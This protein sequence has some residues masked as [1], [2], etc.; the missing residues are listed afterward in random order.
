M[1]PIP[2]VIKETAGID[3][4]A[5]P[6]IGGIPIERG[7]L[8]G[9]PGRFLLESETGEFFNI[10][11]RPAAF[12]PD[13]TAKWLHIT[14]EVD[15]KGGAVNRFKLSPAADEPRA[16][17]G[18]LHVE[19]CG[20]GVSISGGVLDVNVLP[21]QDNLISAAL[22]GTG[23]QQTVLKAPG[24]S[25][26]LG[27]TGPDGHN[28]RL[29]NMEV[30][31]GAPERCRPADRHL[32]NEGTEHRPVEIVAAGAERVVVRLGGYFRNRTGTP[33]AE[34]VMFIEVL[35]Q[36]PELRLQPVFIYMGRVNDDLVE[37]L[38]LTVHTPLQSGP[39]CRYAFADER[40]AFR[41]L[42]Q[43]VRNAPRTGGDGPQWPLARQVQLGSDYY[44]TEKN[45]ALPDASWLKAVEGRRAQGWC[46]LEDGTRGVTAAMRYYWQEYPHSLGVDVNAGTLTFGL[47]PPQARA[48]D[49]RRYSPFR[50][51]GTMYETGE[52]PYD[53]ELHGPYGIAKSHELMVRFHDCG[54]PETAARALSF[55]RPCR[56]L[57]EPAH[58]KRTGVLGR[59]ATPADRAAPKAEEAIENIVE[60]I[61]REREF[62]GWYGLMD[63]G[64][65]MSSFYSDRDR[66]AYDD[67]GYAWINAESLPDLGLWISAFSS[68]PLIS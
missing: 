63:Y 15:L 8:P 54:D 24:I 51:G 37:R 46:S 64:D 62:R 1:K 34:L 5:D 6:V 11:G 59:V 55:T 67:G 44:R 26:R 13:G 16:N 18:A 3:R 56:P 2:V 36:R 7:E 66:W 45:T 22:S 53:A 43:P 30:G 19:N 50:Y 21:D 48:L 14:G 60:F 9:E 65:I 58:L 23:Q 35:R 27:F 29:Y 10:E 20:E 47:I 42:L 57:A 25:A 32:G 33:V 31:D 61:R 40:G 68:A 49:L 41:D 12:W 38:T 4:S 17:G 39:E 28:T 52:G